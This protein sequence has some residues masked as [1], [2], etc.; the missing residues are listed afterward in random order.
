MMPAFL[1]NLAP[2]TFPQWGTFSLLLAMF[3]WALA[4]WI[5][6]EPE[7]TRAKSE[8]KALDNADAAILRAEYQALHQKNRD[9]YHK[10]ANDFQKLVGTQRRCEQALAEAH[11][12]NRMYRDDVNTLLFLIR[13]LISEV[14]RLDR[15]P[16]NII[17][18]QAEMTL[19]ELER[20]RGEGNGVKA[21]GALAEDAV[22]KAE[23]S[24]DAA[25]VT[26]NEITGE[27]AK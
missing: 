13:L 5:R 15:D 8:A 6:G 24:L 21:L 18:K 19:T 1:A 27:I 25:V 2:G 12:E 14:K 22:E 4:V 17:I 10:L 3:V 9:D 11:A 23:A 26:K 7:R 16:A 20:K